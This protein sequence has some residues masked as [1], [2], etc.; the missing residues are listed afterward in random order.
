MSN[1]QLAKNLKYLRKKLDMKQDDVRTM[2][3]ISRQ[4]YSNYERGNRTPDLDTLLYL[5]DFYDVTLN[6][7]VLC[8]LSG[9]NDTFDTLSE[10]DI[11]YNVSK[12]QKSNDILYISDT[13]LEM[14]LSFR[15]LPKDKQTLIK[16]FLL[17]D[18]K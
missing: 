17:N 7:L 2:L 14:I 10:G 15:N 13:E 11:P 12:L 18:N 4:A 8:N 3:N 5:A 6:D 16:G 1:I 9:E